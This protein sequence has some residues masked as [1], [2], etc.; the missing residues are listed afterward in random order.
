[1]ETKNKR[2]Q[3]RTCF[4]RPRQKISLAL[5]FQG[6]PIPS[7]SHVKYHEIFSSKDSTGA[8]ISRQKENY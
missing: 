1:M 4:F 2:R 5:T 3:V 7:Q 8:P 6:A